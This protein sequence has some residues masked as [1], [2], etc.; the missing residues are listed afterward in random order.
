MGLSSGLFDHALIT[1]TNLA[2]TVFLVSGYLYLFEW[3]RTKDRS[4][5][6][7]S[8]I[9]VALSTWSRSAEPFWLVPLFVATVVSLARRDWKSVVF[10]PAVILLIRQPWQMFEK[11]HAKSQANLV[12]TASDTIQKAAQRIDFSTLPSVLQYYWENVIAPNG[13]LYS[14]FIF[15]AAIILLRLYKHRAHGRD[16]TILTLIL[17]N[18][19]GT[20][21]GIYYFSVFYTAWRDIGGSAQRMSLFFGPLIIYFTAVA[22]YQIFGTRPAKS[23]K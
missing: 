19:F 10:Y 15:V 4:A 12:S 23:R 14:I 6:I 16:L 9:M 11:S 13:L 18:I 22:T 1:Y 21:A 2:Y 8:A 5:L 3:L 17:L 7:I 20:F